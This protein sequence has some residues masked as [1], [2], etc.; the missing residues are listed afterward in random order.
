MAPKRKPGPVAV[1]PEK[2][3]RIL[4]D[5]QTL[6]DAFAAT[7][8]KVGVRTIERYRAEQS[9]DPEVV[10]FVAL[11][12][13]EI[14][15]GW[16]LA[17]RAHRLQL[18]RRQAVLVERRNVKLTAVTNALRRTHE[19]IATHELLSDDDDQS[20]GDGG[21]EDSREGEGAGAASTERE[22]G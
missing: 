21:R 12:L 5:A 19:M 17:G 2:V 1:P 11:Y 14:N 9:T 13:A 22:S 4:V 10:K 7:R 18:I 3:A 15:D 16:I 8:H 20:H 6:G